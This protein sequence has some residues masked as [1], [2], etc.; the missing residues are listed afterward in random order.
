MQM[1]ILFIPVK[2]KFTR[3]EAP[4]KRPPP[5]MKTS[6]R[7]TK[8]CIAYQSSYIYRNVQAQKGMIIMLKR[9]VMLVTLLLLSALVF[10][11]CLPY[12]PWGDLLNGQVSLTP[13]WPAVSADA[14]VL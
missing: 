6:S 1:C 12:D 11:G 13:P 4:V 2:R 5:T 7:Q 10:S 9:K 3:R 8:R 14:N